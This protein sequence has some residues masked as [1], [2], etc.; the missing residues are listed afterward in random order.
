M[1]LGELVALKARYNRVLSISRIILYAGMINRTHASCS[2]KQPRL[3]I[4]ISRCQDRSFNKTFKF[5]K[6]DH[7]LRLKRLTA[8]AG[9]VDFDT[10]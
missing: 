3:F 2:S 8:A 4:A 1:L 9:L 7:P 5:G 6:F 10:N